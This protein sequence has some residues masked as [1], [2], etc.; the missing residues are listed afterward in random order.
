MAR[1]RGKGE[2]LADD[3]TLSEANM[4]VPLVQAV[5][6]S[7]LPCLSQHDGLNLLGGRRVN[8]TSREH[9]AIARAVTPKITTSRSHAVGSGSQSMDGVR[10]MSI[11]SAR[12]AAPIDASMRQV[13]KAFQEYTRVRTCLLYTSPSPRDVEE[14]RMPSS[15]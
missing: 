5:G 15:A 6:R 10:Q 1:F 4:I 2:R 7:E 11:H 3:L 8:A 9:T 14:S 13:E 12:W